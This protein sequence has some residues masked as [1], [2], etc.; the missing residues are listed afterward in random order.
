MRL[1]TLFLGILL[2]LTL[3]TPAHA[4]PLIPAIIAAI[5]ITG[6]I[7]VAIA[8]VVLEVAF[9]IATSLLINA[10][11]G[12]PS[13]Q[14]RQAAVTTLAIGESP[15]TAIFGRAAVGGTLADAFNWGGTYGTDYEALIIVLADHKCTALHQFYVN[16]QLI[17]YPPGGWAGGIV[18]DPGGGVA[19]NGQLQVFWLDGSAAQTL[20]SVVTNGGWATTGNFHGVSVAVVAYKADDPQ[21]QNP[22]WSGGRP[23]FLWVVDG[24]KCYDPRLDSTV[25]GGSG[26]HRWADPTTWAWTDNAS[27]C[28]YNW[29]RG[30]YALDQVTD[31]QSLLMGRG[32]TNLEAPEVNVFAYANFCDESVPLLA[33]GSEKR[34]TVNGVIRSNERYVDT[35]KMFAD[36]MGGIIIQPGGSVEVEP[37]HARSPTFSFTDDDLIVGTRVA[38]SP[39]RSVAD[40]AWINTIIPRYVEPTQKWQDHAAPVRRDPA[41]VTADGEAREVGMALTMVTS[42]TQA[43]RLGEIQRRLGRLVGTATVTLGPRF[44]GIEEGDW[45]TWSSARHR[46]G[47]GTWRVEAYRIDEKRQVTLTLRE[48]NSAVYDWTTADEQTSGVTAAGSSAPDPAWLGAYG[49]PGLLTIDLISNSRPGTNL[50]ISATSTPTIIISTHSR[51]YS[52]RTVS[53][54][55]ATLTGTWA[56]GSTQYI[57]YDDPARKGGAVTYRTTTVQGDA[58]SSSTNPYRHYVGWVIIPASGTVTGFSAASS[59]YGFAFE[60]PDPTPSKPIAEFASPVSWNVQKGL[61][62]SVG[63]I[64]DSPTNTATAPSAQTDFDIQSPVGTSIGTMRFAASSLTATFIMAADR[65]IPAAQSFYII[66]PASLNGLAGMVFGAIGGTR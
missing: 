28:R 50:T 8:T 59:S 25:A 20:P 15:R 32:L 46:A 26:A 43:Q 29:V 2:A 13:Q 10:I 40:N 19:Y 24:K 54:T 44:G 27:V 11:A 38:T 48:I 5:G 57:Y 55:G 9:A 1:R 17:T 36:A 62:T 39:F 33:G 66:P 52:D 61:T 60:W 18:P 23:S 53:V 56:A 34:Y 31:P 22:V 21:S 30:I 64:G 37:G 58:I 42:G 51:I 14:P 65:A 41:D 47:S 3:P 45:G 4:G 16:D 49:G 7:G 12:S 6:T 35:E 63:K